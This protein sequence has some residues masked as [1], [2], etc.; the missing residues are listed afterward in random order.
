MFLSIKV[1]HITAHKHTQMKRRRWRAQVNSYDEY[2][3]VMKA[4]LH[5]ILSQWR[6]IIDS[7]YAKD[8]KQK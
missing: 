3:H 2:G 6:M 1:L 8:I 5:K 7:E 4:G